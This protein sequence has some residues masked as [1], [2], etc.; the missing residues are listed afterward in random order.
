MGNEI[1]IGGTTVVIGGGNSLPNAPESWEQFY[2]WVDDA[3]K[4]KEEHEEP[5][6]GT[7]C[8]FK[9][10]FDGPLVCISSRFYPSANYY[11]PTW[12]GR[13]SLYVGSQEIL[14]KKFDYPTFA[15]LVK[16]VE[17]YVESLRTEIKS[18]L[19]EALKKYVE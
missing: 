5:M 16:A 15:E 4:D 10:D 14:E 19:I 2:K 7:D 8:N 3:N 1:I 9:L 18:A 13:V 17:V 12:D 11:G 6:W